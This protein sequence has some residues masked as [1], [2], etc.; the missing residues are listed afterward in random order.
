M[1]DAECLARRGRCRSVE[2]KERAVAEERQSRRNT[3]MKPPNGKKTFE[4]KD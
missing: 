2:I 1:R 4:Q 3:I